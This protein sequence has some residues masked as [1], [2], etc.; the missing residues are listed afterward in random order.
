MWEERSTHAP[1]TA[2]YDLH[3][4]NEA[5]QVYV[6]KG[7]K[8]MLFSLYEPAGSQKWSIPDNNGD[9]GANVAVAT[10]AE[11]SST[12]KPLDDLCYLARVLILPLMSWLISTP[13]VVF[14]KGS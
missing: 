2:L 12:F 10:T 6:A 3:Y 4:N 14:K 1:H 11:S 9:S 8:T 5:Q 7:I 13:M